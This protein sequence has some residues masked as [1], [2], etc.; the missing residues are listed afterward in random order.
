M[1]KTAAKLAQRGPIET[2]RG[3]NVASGRWSAN[4]YERQTNYLHAAA[5][6]AL[7]ELAKHA[8]AGWSGVS[9]TAEARCDWIDRAQDPDSLARRLLRHARQYERDRRQK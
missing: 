7:S 3:E 6:D 9:D 4:D 8:R 2:K 1:R 5:R